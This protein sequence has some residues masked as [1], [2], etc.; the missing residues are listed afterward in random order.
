MVIGKLAISIY[1]F[2]EAKEFAET[3]VKGFTLLWNQMISGDD[4]SR[5]AVNGIQ[6]AVSLFNFVFKYLSLN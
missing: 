2:V 5:V 1:I 4:V 6:R 3:A